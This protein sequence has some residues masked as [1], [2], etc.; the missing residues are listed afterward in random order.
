M[1]EGPR[2]TTGG[3]RVLTEVGP[4]VALPRGKLGARHGGRA[5]RSDSVNVCKPSR[6]CRPQTSPLKCTL[7]VNH[8]ANQGVT[9]ESTGARLSDEREL[10]PWGT[11]EHAWSAKLL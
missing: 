1:E 2:N 8:L 11:R 4:P 6:L 3:T 7:A 10:D 9:I 5:F